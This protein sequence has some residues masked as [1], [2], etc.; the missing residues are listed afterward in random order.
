MGRAGPGLFDSDSFWDAASDLIP[1]VGVDLAHVGILDFWADDADEVDEDDPI[2]LSIEDTA[3]HLNDGNSRRA[4]E[5]LKNRN[6]Y[7]MLIILVVLSM[8]VGANIEPKYVRY[9]KS[10]YLYAETWE[11]L[12]E[13]REQIRVA[14]EEYTS[15]QPYTFKDFDFGDDWTQMSDSGEAVEMMKVGPKNY[16]E[17]VLIQECCNSCKAGETEKGVLKRPREPDDSTE[18][19]CV[20]RTKLAT[21]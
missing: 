13:C 15:G 1:I 7:S 17:P 21:E 3:A 6:N 4:F 19:D 14:C 10:V 16:H 9:I 18:T 11:N 8:K 5:V 20:K 12:P 2:V